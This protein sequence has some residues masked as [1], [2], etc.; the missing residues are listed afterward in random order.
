MVFKRRSAAP[1][2]R[3]TRRRLNFGSRRVGRRR[4]SRRMNGRSTTNR[5]S[6][7]SSLG[8]K[9]RRI[10]TS[11]FRRIIWRDTLSA[12]HWRSVGDTNVV[13]ATPNNIV[14]GNLSVNNALANNFW[15]TGGGAQPV[16]TAGT[17][18]L[19]TGDITLRG[20]ISRITCT[21]RVNP[22]DTQPSDPVRVTIFAVWT[23]KAPDASVVLPTPPS[24]V[25]TMWDPSLVPDF[26]RYGKVMFKREALLKGDGEVISCYFRY[27]PQK[28]DQN[29]FN[30]SGG[31]LQ[32]F[33]VV[34]QT[35]NT[36]AVA[37][38]ENIDIVTSWNLSFSGDAIG[39]T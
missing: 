4:F 6:S 32:W 35:S 37:Q 13:Q 5:A 16:D 15:T 3:R 9:N 21:N 31:R 12:Q 2:A 23:K 24:V 11:R 20:G 34:S 29:V 10:T 33:V 36:E 39:T 17:V 26:V 7:A 22:V 14:Q 28:I 30:A 1:F 25:G 18:P 19:F 8:F 27:K 38:A